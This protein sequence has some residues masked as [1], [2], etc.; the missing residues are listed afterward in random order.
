MLPFYEAPYG[1]Q[2]IMLPALRVLFAMGLLVLLI[3]AANTANLLL[4][5]ASARQR[6]TAVRLAVGAS[7]ARLMRQWLVESVLLAPWAAPSD[8]SA[9]CGARVC[10]GS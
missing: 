7:R 2:A 1:G 9:R 4:T 5:R 10:S 8:C 3:V 6:E